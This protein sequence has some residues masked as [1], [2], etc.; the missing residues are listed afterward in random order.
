MPRLT[1]PEQIAETYRRMAEEGRYRPMAPSDGFGNIT[2]PVEEL[3]LDAEARDYAVRWTR[4]E[5]VA[6]FHIG[7]CNYAT[8]PVMILAVEASRLTC[9]G[10]ADQD[11]LTLLRMAVAEMER[12]IEAGDSV[13]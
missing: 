1:S 13:A 4:E 10:D 11:A 7:T 6:A 9:S 12:V 3:D 5:D 2:V 8:R